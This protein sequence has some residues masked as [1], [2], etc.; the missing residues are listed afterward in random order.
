MDELKTKL[1]EQLGLDESVAN[2]AIE[3]V[4]GFVKDK[5]PEGAQG[6]LDSVMG[7]EG[8]DIASGA[9]DKIKGMFGQ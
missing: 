1:M 4:L 8:G 5:L 6:M 7:G 2:S 3:T 9:V